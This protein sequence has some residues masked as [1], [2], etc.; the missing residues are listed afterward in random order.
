MA[1]LQPGIAEVR[2]Q[3]TTD[4]NRAQRGNG[5]D[6]SLSGGRPSGNNYR[7]NG[8]SIND[9][10]NTAPGSAM[11]TNL[12]VDAIQEFSVESSTPAAEYGKVT[13]GI[14]NAI[15]RRAPTACMDRLMTS[16]ATV[17]WTL[18]ISST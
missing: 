4:T 15:T 12:G 13:G 9:Y 2:S 8:I 7:L 11:G 18:A 17:T 10:A 14:I 1:Q 3:N 5:V 16:S 6:L